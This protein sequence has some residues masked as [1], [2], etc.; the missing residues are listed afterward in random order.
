MSNEDCLFLQCD[1]QAATWEVEETCR[2]TKAQIRLP[3]QK[4][5]TN[6]STRL[7]TKDMKVLSWCQLRTDVVSR[8]LLTLWYFRYIYSRG[9]LPVALKSAGLSSEVSVAVLTCPG[10]QSCGKSDVM[11]ETQDAM[12]SFSARNITFQ[13]SRVRKQLPMSVVSKKCSDVATSLFCLSRNPSGKN[14]REKTW[15]VQDKSVSAISHTE[16]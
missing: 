4:P 3:K 10:C 8:A 12:Q 2:P 9:P 5:K 1:W 7:W 11:N 15:S 16:T 14:R 13:A 6:R